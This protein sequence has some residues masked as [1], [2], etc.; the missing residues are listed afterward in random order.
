LTLD[1]AINGWAI[2]IM[3]LRDRQPPNAPLVHPKLNTGKEPFKCG[4]ASAEC[5]VVEQQSN[6]ATKLSGLVA[7]FLGCSKEFPSAGIRFP[8][9]PAPRALRSAPRC[10]C[11]ICR[12]RGNETHFILDWQ[13]RIADFSE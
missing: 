10:P 1:P 11:G 7:W 6:E 2:V 9:S 13:M 3:S 8:S 5:G 4:M 12:S